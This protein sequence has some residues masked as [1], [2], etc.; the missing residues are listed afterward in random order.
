[1]HPVDQVITRCRVIYIP[2]HTPLSVTRE[3][4]SCGVRGAGWGRRLIERVEHEARLCG[5][6]RIEAWS[7][8]RFET[9][10]AVYRRMGYTQ[11]DE[12]RFLHDLSR[13][14]EFFFAKSL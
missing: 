13:T 5:A 12:T 4:K 8:T 10:H 1:M 9:A 6:K 7:D 3:Q 2:R 11:G 14:E